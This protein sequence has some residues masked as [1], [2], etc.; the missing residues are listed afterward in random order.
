MK[1]KNIPHIEINDKDEYIKSLEKSVSILQKEINSLKENQKNSKS[2]I[3]QSIKKYDFLNFENIPKVLEKLHNCINSEINIVE[4]TLLFF[5]KNK[6][7]IKNSDSPISEIMQ[8]NISYLEEEGITDWIIS[9]NEP[10]IIPNLNLAGVTTGSNFLLIPVLILN[11][12]RG[13]FIA[14]TNKTEDDINS[15]ELLS[16]ICNNAAL[17][18]DYISEINQNFLISEKL[19]N[20]EKTIVSNAG[21]ISV[22]E[23]THAITYELEEPIKVINGHL[24]MLENGIGNTES[25]IKIIKKHFEKIDNVITKLQNIEDD[26]KDDFA[27]YSITDIIQEVIKLM[28]SQMLSEDIKIK[29]INESEKIKIKCKYNLMVQLF[30]DIFIFQKNRMPDGGTIS[31]SITG[32]SNKIIITIIDTGIGLDENFKSQIFEPLQSDNTVNLFF[33]KQI[34]ELHKGKI[35]MISEAES[36]NTF[37]IQLPVSELN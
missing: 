30:L 3:L 13:L 15:R 24:N 14:S 32:Q 9:R 2:P 8:T 34:V 10:K 31:I 5:N 6:K 29:F 16:E 19:K 28:H 37:K 35:N 11:K 18:V 12:S 17:V 21:L 33:V 20:L 26:E 1:M 7:L 4:S 25:R 23:I 27:L 22:A 36:G